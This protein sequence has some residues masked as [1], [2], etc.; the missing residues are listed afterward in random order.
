MLCP[1]GGNG[2]AG[3]WRGAPDSGGVATSDRGAL[4]PGPVGRS[5]ME[6]LYGAAR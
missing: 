3:L 2:S 5:D 1:A 6:R 4:G